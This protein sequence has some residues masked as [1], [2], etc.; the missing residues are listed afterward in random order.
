[1]NSVV[2]TDA[3]FDHL[4]MSHALDDPSK[5]DLLEFMG[6]PKGGKR[7]TINRKRRKTNK[8]RRK[9]RRNRK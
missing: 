8:K 5:Q 3:M 4:N 9:T 6:K 1:V 7:K 2:T